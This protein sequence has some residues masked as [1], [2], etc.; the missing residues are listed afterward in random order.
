MVEDRKYRDVINE[1]LD[2]I[3]HDLN[4]LL[5]A[6]RNMG[7]VRRG[8]KARIEQLIIAKRRIRLAMTKLEVP[9]DND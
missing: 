6:V 4:V 2:D 7:R 8:T 1:L 9:Y 3:E 5:V